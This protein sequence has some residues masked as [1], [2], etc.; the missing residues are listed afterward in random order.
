M[1]SSPVSFAS[2]NAATDE[3][4][5]RFDRI[6]DKIK[7]D[8]AAIAALEAA[9]AR[10][11]AEAAQVADL[12]ARSDGSAATA[13]GRDWARRKLVTELA[14]ATRRSERATTRLIDD[15]EHLVTTLPATLKA[16]EAGAISYPHARALIGHAITLPESARTEFE[17][18]AL[19]LAAELPPYRFDDRVRRLRE[20]AHPES[21]TTRTASAREKRYVAFTA[22]CDG[23]A[24]FLH[25][26]PVV[27]ALAIDDLVDRL[28]RA[29][30]SPDTTHAQRRCDALTDLVLGRGEGPRITPTVIVTV[31]AAMLATEDDGARGRVASGVD[32]MDAQADLHGYGPVDPAAARGL[33]ATAPTFLRALIHPTTGVPIAVTR[34]RTPARAGTGTGTGNRNGN[35]NGNGNGTMSGTISASGGSGSGTP[36]AGR[37]RYSA[38]PMLRTVLMI[39]DETCRFPGCGRRASRCE[40]DHTIAWVEGGETTASNLAHLCTKHHHLKHEGGWRVTSAPDTRSLTWTSPRGTRYTTTPPG[41]APPQPSPPHVA[42]PQPCPPHVAP[43]HPCP[44]HVAPPHPCPPHV[45]PPRLVPPSLAPPCLTPPSNV[46]PSTVPPDLPPVDWHSRTPP[47]HP[48]RTSAQHPSLAAPS[49]QPLPAPSSSVTPGDVGLRSTLSAAELPHAASEGPPPF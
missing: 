5:D 9:R 25:H 40:L 49:A 31:P 10:S 30:H 19:P 11:F 35:G 2:H 39:A 26:L 33:A 21:I 43:P 16:L 29:S 6:V 42:P 38:S 4:G 24:T 20:R 34:H 13:T 8:D 37:A 46:P 15:A 47:P 3:L 14:C 44:P 28:A 48:I 17:Q 45:A 32:L 1:S 36:D 23:M 12:M 22:E 7:A 18:Q 41:L 27:D